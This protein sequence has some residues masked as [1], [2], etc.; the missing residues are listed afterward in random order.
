MQALFAAFHCIARADRGRHVR[1]RD[2]G[3]RPA[4]ATEAR[5]PLRP[6]AAGSRRPD[7]ATRQGQGRRISHRSRLGR[8][9][10]RGDVGV[11]ARRTLA[12]RRPQSGAHRGGARQ[13]Q[14]G[15]RQRP[16]HLRAEE[17]VR[18]RHRQGRHR[19]DVSPAVGQSRP[20]AEGAAATCGRARAS[21]PTP[22]TW[23]TG[24]PTTRRASSAARS[25]C[26]S[27]RRAVEGRWTIEGSHKFTVTIEQKYQKI[28]GTAEIGGKPVPLRDASL[29]GAEIGFAIDINGHAATASRASSTAT[30]STAGAT[31]GAATAGQIARPCSALHNVCNH[32]ECAMPDDDGQAQPRAGISVLQ[33]SRSSSAS[34][35]ASASSRRPQ[36]VAQ[37]VASED[38]VHRAVGRRRPDHAHRRAGLCRARLRLS[39]RRRRVPFPVARARAAGRRCCSPGRASPSCRPASSRRS[40]SCSATMRSSWSRLGPGGRRSMPRSRSRPDAGE[41]LGTPQGKGFQLV[42]TT[43]TIWPRSSPW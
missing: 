43:L 32:I 1:G 34:S 13:R 14:E 33:A 22:S 23:A 31:N 9:P 21:S 37:N 28:T 38:D 24:S 26:G 29:N 18:D 11:E 3:H 12:R 7:A 36:L 39:S 27:S 40:R 16:R 25:I 20:A 42:L 5:R 4:A 6:D 35:S 15:Q 10:H 41:L 30:G 2:R 8:R 19:H 17:P